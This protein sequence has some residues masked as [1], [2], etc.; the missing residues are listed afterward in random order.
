MLP[1]G[2]PDTN[3]HYPNE[4]LPASTTAFAREALRE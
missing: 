4:R 3:E 1:F 2:E